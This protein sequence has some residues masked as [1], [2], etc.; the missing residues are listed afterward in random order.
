MQITLAKTIEL[1]QAWMAKDEAI[2]YFGYQLH[3]SLFQKLLREFKEHKD[4]KDGYRLVT[5]GLPIIHIQKFDEFLVWRDKNKYKRN[6][7]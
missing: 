2:I 1:P 6:K 4:F 5:S 7:N 3:K